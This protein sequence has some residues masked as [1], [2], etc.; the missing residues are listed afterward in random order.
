LD[1]AIH[2]KQPS[3]EE[4]VVDVESWIKDFQY[5]EKGNIRREVGEDV[6]REAGEVKAHIY[7]QAN[8]GF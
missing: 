4:I 6:R 3:L 8:F 5:V 2:Q 1:Y 7:V